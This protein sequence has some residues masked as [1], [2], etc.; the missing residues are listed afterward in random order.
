MKLTPWGAVGG[1]AAFIGVLCLP[2][3]YLVAMRTEVDDATRWLPFTLPALLVVG[4]LALTLV[5]QRRRSRARDR[6]R[7]HDRR[8]S[9]PGST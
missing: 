7:G 6:R 8:P 5:G 9:H 2:I 3:A 4:G 1:V